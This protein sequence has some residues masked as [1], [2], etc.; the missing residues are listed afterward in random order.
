MLGDIFGWASQQ[1]GQLV[2][3]VIPIAGHDDRQI[4]SGSRST[5]LWH[6]ED[7][8]HPYRAD[9]VALMCLRNPDATATTFACIDDV[10]VPDDVRAILA[11]PR[12][13]LHPDESHRPEYRDPRLGEG[14]EHTAVLA[15]SYERIE[16]LLARPEKVPILFGDHDRPYVRLDSDAVDWDLDDV[17]AMRALRIFAAAVDRALTDHSLHAGDLLFVDNY[18]AVHGRKPFVATFDGGD[19]WLKR[20]NISRDLRRSRDAR[21]STESRIVY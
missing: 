18:R 4:N 10:D 8:F 13:V 6:T 20:L 7:A 19:R 15:R 12:F 2:H 16:R 17:V 1:N 3:E 11:Q 9:Y 5:L 14:S 21:V